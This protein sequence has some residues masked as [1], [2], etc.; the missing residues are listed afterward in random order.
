MSDDP[1]PQRQEK[2]AELLAILNRDLAPWVFDGSESFAQSLLALI[3]ES[4]PSSD[5]RGTPEGARMSRKKM[6][7][8]M[9][10]LRAMWRAFMALP[11][12]AKRPA[13]RW[14]SE[15]YTRD[16]ADRKRA[17]DILFASS[18]RLVDPLAAP[19]AHQEPAK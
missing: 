11:D 14:M 3:V 19:S 9:K 6:D 12:D 5:L 7:P 16:E 1:T 8:E 18:L 4:A 13:L 2:K 15:R 17:A 10:H